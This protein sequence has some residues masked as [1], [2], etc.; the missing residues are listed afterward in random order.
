MT[1]EEQTFADVKSELRTPGYRDR[2]HL[3]KLSRGKFSTL[4]PIENRPGLLK[5]LR[6]GKSF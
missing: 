1:F 5:V 6:N 2:D 4:L 3:L